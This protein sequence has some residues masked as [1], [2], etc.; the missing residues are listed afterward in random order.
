MLPFL[1]KQK[2]QS[3]IIVKN[4]EPDSKP[5]GEQADN[6]AI[7]TCMHD[8]IKAIHSRDARAASEAIKD[9]FAVLESMPHEEGEHSDPHSYSAQNQAAADEE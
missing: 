4:R 6:T 1:N 2:Q 3:G 8:L 5:E 9:V 7:E